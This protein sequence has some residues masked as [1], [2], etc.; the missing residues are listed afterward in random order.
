MKDNPN[1][2][3]KEVDIN[4]KDIPKLNKSTDGKLY[5]KKNK[6]VSDL[7]PK[8]LKEE[9]LSW[10][11]FNMSKIDSDDFIKLQT[12][13]GIFD[14]GEISEKIHYQI[15][16]T[17]KHIENS[18]K[19]KLNSIKTWADE[20]SLD[21][22]YAHNFKI[23]EQIKECDKG[24][25]PESTREFL[26]RYFK[27]DKEEYIKFMQIE[28][29]IIKFY[30]RKEYC[31]EPPSNTLIDS[32]NSFPKKFEIPKTLTEDQYN[33]I[34]KILDMLPS[35]KYLNEAEKFY[36][37]TAEAN[38]DFFDFWN[39]QAIYLESIGITLLM[40]KSK[41]WLYDTFHVLIKIKDKH[42]LVKLLDK[43]SIKSTL[44]STSFFYLTNL[45]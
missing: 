34:I 44:S 19:E 25:C 33:T 23:I 42:K 40:N 37:I 28:N 21:Q 11:N 10:I 22:W 1:E 38:D 9:S 12:K 16:N 15:K 2:K 45:F 5:I 30:F 27:G 31:S 13:Y 3:P 39:Y 41:G 6:S 43:Y 35:E 29:K 18:I 24:N 26:T 32:F 14:V 17:P 20:F 4:I 7:I 8:N 36:T